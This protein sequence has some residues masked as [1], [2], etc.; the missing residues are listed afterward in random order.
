MSSPILKRELRSVLQTRRALAIVIVLSLSFSMIV[1]LRWPTDGQVEISGARSQ[2]MFQAFAYTLLA[3]VL[4]VI[5][6]FP[7]TAIVLEKRRGTLALLLNSPLRAWTI[8]LGKFTGAVL[9]AVLVLM[10]SLPSAA[11]CYAMGG[12]E[13][14]NQ[15]GLLYVV[16]LACV[17]QYT[18]IALL[19]SS[20]V[21]SNDAA[22]RWT[23]AA[24]LA[25]G[26]LS[27]APY[28]FLQG[29]TN[30]LSSLSVPIPMG[31]STVTNF[32]EWVDQCLHSGSWYL[33]AASPVPIVMALAGHG[34]VG[35][36]G[37]QESESTETWFFILTGVST[38][39]L[40]V[41]TISRLNFRIFDRNRSKGQITEERGLG[42]RILR[43]I[44][45]LV[46]PQ[47]RKARIP[48]FLNPVMVKEFR[49]RKFGRAHWLLRLIAGCAILSLLFALAATGG[50]ADWEPETIGGFMVLLQIVL[51]VL[52]V[53]SLTA[54]LISTER[55]TGGWELLRMTPV[56]T[57][58]I[59]LGKLS[60]VLWT[61][62]LILMATL[63]GYLVMIYIKPAMWGQ[64]QLVLVCLGLT[65]IYTVCVGAAVGAL[66]RKTTSATMACYIVLIVIFLG[67]LLIWLGLDNPFS[68]TVVET[69]LSINPTG[70]ALSIMGAPGFAAFE[71][72]RTAWIVSSVVSVVSLL[73][74]SCQ[75]W[76]ITRPV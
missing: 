21:Q 53:P 25:V 68:H 67:P 22:V 56:S 8:Y 61:V 71:L 74:L 13:L 12:L 65:A 58:K 70:A 14:T 10:T 9:F 60:S 17:V 33:R 26:V 27:V 43:R 24:V 11:A 75:V 16:L 66:F 59:V 19:V 15:L 2:Q 29:K 6:A 20:Y 54:G 38:F 62:M 72:T 28:L 45:F 64:V 40:A 39:V 4:L 31:A 5:P 51:F 47:R 3:A 30:L 1:M 23:Y 36:M 52:V 44:V 41:V 76:R 18:T 7:A 49:T 46:D 35:D 42:A 55:E 48:F 50:V 37:I 63:P 34:G 73:L 69:A 32:L 57:F